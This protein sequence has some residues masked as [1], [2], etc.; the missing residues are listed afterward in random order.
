VVYV[1]KDGT[2]QELEELVRQY[3]RL[4]VDMR[5]FEN[6]WAAGNKSLLRFIA[7]INRNGTSTIDT[8]KSTTASAAIIPDADGEITAEEGS[9]LDQMSLE[10]LISAHLEN[11]YEASN[12][13]DNAGNEDSEAELKR[14]PPVKSRA[15]RI[16]EQKQRREKQSQV[17]LTHTH[18]LFWLQK[19][20]LLEFGLPSKR[21]KFS[22]GWLWSVN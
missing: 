5:D 19:Y 21:M 9:A 20:L 15:E 16:A 11:V 22:N 4:Q 18:N 2:E 6:L 17:C 14:G 12:G 7:S 3:T 13:S 1:E 10:A 8:V